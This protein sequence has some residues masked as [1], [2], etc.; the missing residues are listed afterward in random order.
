MTWLRS[1]WPFFVLHVGAMLPILLLL[2]NLWV[3]D[4]GANPVQAATLRTGKVALICLVLTLACSPIYALFGW[5]HA[6]ALRRWLGLYAFFYAGVHF[7]IF[8]GLD[9]GFQP[10]LFREVFLYRRYALVGFSSGVILT[11]LALTST[12]GWMQRLGRGWFR[13]HRMVY[14]AAILAVVHYLW[15]VKADLRTPLIY[16]G[17]ILLL[18]LLRI[19]LL[20]RFL[21]SVKAR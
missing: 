17:I 5:R 10:A 20:S 1:K 16:A 6:L 7:L 19:P 12:K 13:L 18:L 15:L 4:L 9:Y 21:E 14:L 11:L 8:A 2:L 3:G